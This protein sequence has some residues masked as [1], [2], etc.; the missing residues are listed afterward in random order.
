[1]KQLLFILIFGFSSSLFAQ[2]PTGSI[3]GNV[4]LEEKQLMLHHVTVLIVQLSRSTETDELGQFQFQNIPPGTYDLVASTAG[5]ASEL[6]TVQVTAGGE[7]IVNFALKLS[8]IRQEITVTASGAQETAFGSFLSVNSM[9][10]F[11][12]AEEGA[13]AIGEVLEAQPGVA[14]RSFGPGAARPVIRGFDGDRVLVLQDGVKTGSLASQSGDH[15]EPIDVLQLD[16]LEVVKGPATLLYGSNAIGGVVNA[17]SGHHQM[18]E[19]AQD[20][21]RGYLTGIGGVAN[22]YGGGGAGIEY[23]KNRWLFW[24]SGGN[25]STGDYHTPAGKVLNSETRITTGLAGFG[26]FGNRSFLSFGYDYNDGRYGI[27]SGEGDEE[28]EKPD[29]LHHEADIDYFRRNLRVSG[30]IQHMRSFLE[31]ARFTFNYSNWNHK[32]L[33]IA[34]ET[35]EV[36]TFFQNKQY[37]WNAYFDQ[38]RYG[39]LSGTLGFSGMQRDYFVQGEEA[40]TPPAKQNVLAFFA[41]EELDFEHLKVQFGA[42]LESTRYH[43]LNLHK[44]SFTGASG[45]LGAHVP[46][47]PGGALVANFTHSYRAPALEELYN[48]GPHLGNLTFE[49]GNPELKRERSDGVDLSLR[50]LG[51]EL[52]WESNFYYYDLGNFVYLAPTGERIDELTEAIYAQA[53]ARFVGTEVTA[54]FSLHPNLWLNAGLDYVHAELR[55]SSTPLP[56]IPPLRGRFGFHIRYR[57]LS[58]K[59]EMILVNEQERIF[60]TETRTAGYSVANLAVSYTLPLTHFSHHFAV[61]AFNLGN[62]LYRNHVSFI[63][64]LVPEIG[65]GIRFTYSVKFF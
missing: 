26:W 6:Q 3:K 25:Q 31:G 30:G 37:T 28:H 50:H 53:G 39:K 35:E 12:L 44:R 10:S 48:R 22:R 38:R 58:I 5:I 20:G 27:P 40:L 17:V 49:I 62:R 57:E 15:G 14:K 23:A 32:E 60:R 29:H 59:P 13:T 41:L 33:E 8:P 46:L 24:A 43:P 65:R 16:R 61:N 54:D 36:G 2:V 19:Q 42:R 52:Q 45:S 51:Q 7:A 64:D 21:T 4:Q 1:M 9:D 47:W 18:K 56:R 63:K 34:E 11:E 55:G